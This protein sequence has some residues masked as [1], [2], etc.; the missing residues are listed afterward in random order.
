MRS[1]LSWVACTLATSVP[2]VAVGQE[3]SNANVSLQEVVV[4]G[5]SIRGVASPGSPT[6]NLSREDFTA[7]GASTSSDLARMLPQ[8]INLGADESRLGGAQDGA[9]N[10]T[11]VSGINLRGIGNEA[12]LLLVDGRRLAPAGVI[13]SLYDPNVIPTSA[14][15]R[16]EVVVDG[17]SAIYGSDAVAGVVNIITRKNFQGAET[18]LRYGAADGTNQRIASQNLGYTWNGGSLFAAIE[19]NERDN[20]PGAD[21]DFASTDRRGRGGS[22]ARS[23]LASPG[24]ILSGTTRYP[25]PSTNGIDVAPSQLNA[26][27]AN[28]F[29]DGSFADLLPDQKRTSLF[30]SAH[31]TF[32][33]FDAWYQG[34]YSRRKFTERVAPASG[35]LR[36]PSTNA[37]FVAPA[38]LG[39]PSTVTVE[40]RFLAED[41]DPR[42]TGHENAQQNAVGLTFDA[43]HDWQIQAYANLSANHG[44]QR[45]GAI[46]NGAALTQA[47]ASSDPATAFNPFGDGTFNVTNNPGLVDIIIANRDTYG[48]STARDY[49][50]K[51][52][53]PL[54]ALPGGLVRF[55]AGVERHDNEFRQ[56]LDANNVLASGEVTTKRVLN[57][58]HNVAEFAELFVPIVGEPNAVKGVRE[59][60]L[61]LAGRREEYSDFGSTTDPKVGITFRPIESLTARATY[62]TSFRAPSLVDT[63]EQIHN[64]FI[65]NLTDPTG[66][67][68][69][70]RGI[71]HNGG[72]ASLSPEQA[73]TWSF[74]LDWRPQG[75]LARLSASATY[76][77]VDY[78]DRID[79]V[80][81]TALTNPGVYAPYIVRRPAASDAAAT[82]AFDA[83]VQSF[84]SNPD[85]QSPVEPVANINA[86]VDGRRANLGSLRQNGL[87]VNLAYAFDTGVGAWR[88]ALDGAKILDLTRSTA[89][90]LPHVDVLDT[91][92]NPV[93]LRARMSLAWALRGWRANAFVNYV[94]GYKNTAITPNVHVESYHTVDATLGYDFGDA[95]GALNGVDLSL[96][97][98]DLF[99]EDPPVVLNGTVSWDNQNV[100]PLGRFVSLVVTKRW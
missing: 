94:S 70:T 51:A 18:M 89:P 27:S 74:G 69:I 54:F 11:R 59:L 80:P 97:A 5:T 36:V 30:L 3:S 67:G 38:A 88:V 68:G 7:S 79:V 82:A 42:L 91:F 10:T 96:N 40:Y 19:H 25:L 66:T 34:W 53:G 76:Y 48:T 29:D 78:S 15:E 77:R 21:R 49:A 1:R 61:S 56:R 95:A 33:R 47:L 41:S 31:Q 84:L 100:S 12:T 86:I 45:R 98:L 55:A 23:T 64:I 28:V 87:D 60:S 99:D 90:G 46:T 71:F 32:G 63:S 93:D 13:K 20:L 6:V 4:T 16:L 9:A 81:A 83:L 85:L 43:G 75:A 26:G 52:D 37:W 44:F 39:T 65:Q 17:A 24:N 72:R 58:R 8:V 35:Q 22:D 57:R 50:L 62:G 2:M 92:G 73:T 14:V